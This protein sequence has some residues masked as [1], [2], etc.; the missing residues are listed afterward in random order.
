MAQL[1]RPFQVALGACVL[2]ALLWFALLHR[3]GSGSTSSSSGPSASVG[4]HPSPVVKP[5]G[6]PAAG[7]ADPAT[8]AVRHAS[9]DTGVRAGAHGRARTHAHTPAKTT[10][11]VPTSATHAHAPTPD[12]ATHS[13]AT[14][15]PAAPSARAKPAHGTAKR[16]APVGHSGATSHAPAAARHATVAPPP[17]ASTTAPSTSSPPPLQAAVATE[18]KQGKIALLLFWNPKASDDAAVHSQVLAVAHKLGGRVAV[19]TA[20]AGQ[21]GAFGSIT[22]DI[23]IYQTPTLLIVDR[24]DQVTTLTGYTEAFAIEQAIGEARAAARG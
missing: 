18:L 22:R 17:H 11:S 14:G 20:L 10:S 7:K 1:S 13:H 12:T 5:A 23:Q 8:R 2:F 9:T 15:S 6:T 4:T 19:H 16:T 21:V 24:Q 3:P